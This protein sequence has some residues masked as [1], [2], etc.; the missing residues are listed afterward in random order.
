M[1]SLRRDGNKVGAGTSDLWHVCLWIHRL[2]LLFGET[3]SPSLWGAAV[4]LV[5]DVLYFK[6]RDL[7]P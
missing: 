3:A 4:G 5:L 1:S 2:P 7:P 6:S